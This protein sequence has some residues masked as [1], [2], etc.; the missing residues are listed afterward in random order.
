MT[1]KI[2]KTTWRNKW[3]TSGATS[4][5]DFINVFE[6]LAKQ[7]REWKDLGIKLEDDGGVSDDYATFIVDDMDVA[8]QA[9]FTYHHIKDRKKQYLITIDNEEIEVPKEKYKEK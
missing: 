1:K 9:G 2:Y 6:F 3:I 8:I 5:D 7:F 4:I